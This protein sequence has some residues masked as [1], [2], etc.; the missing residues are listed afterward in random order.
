M[1]LETTYTNSEHDQMI[2]DLVGKP[3]GF[4]DRIKKRGIGSKRMIVDEVSPNMSQYLNTVDDLNYANIELRP[5]GIL[6]RINKGLKN[7]TWI[8]PYY[9]LVMYKT[10]GA[11]IHAQGKYIRFRE[12]RT[13]KE[14]KGFFGKMLDE[15]IEH[16]AQYDFY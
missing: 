10:N 16:D 5:G 4:Y 13:F 14:N 12:N 1:V 3:Y 15:K 2:N 8:I 7:F 6:I 11:S 9:H